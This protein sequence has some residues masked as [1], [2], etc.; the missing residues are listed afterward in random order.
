[1]RTTF[2]L[3]LAC[4]SVFASLGQ[5]LHHTFDTPE[6]KRSDTLNVVHYDVALD[7]TDSVNKEIVGLAKVTVLSK[8]QGLKAIKLD[9]LELTVDSVWI[10]G[11][12]TT[13]WTYNDTFL[14]IST[15]PKNKGDTT[16]VKV[17]YHGVPF[18]ERWGGW[19]N[20]AN[21]IFNLGVG[22]ESIPHNLGKV[23]HPCLDNFINRATYTVTLK[24]YGSWVGVGSGVLTQVDT[25]Q[26]NP[27]IIERTWNL[28][29]AIPTYLY[30][31]ASGR[32]VLL[33]DTLSGPFTTVTSDFYV[34]PNQITSIQSKTQRLEDCFSLFEQ[35]YGKYR[36]DRVGY[37]TTSQG[38]MEHATNIAIPLSAPETTI[39]HE[40]AHSW[41]GNLITCAS[42]RDMWINEGMAVFSE[43]LFAEDAY[44]EETAR[45]NMQSDL[46]TVL[47]SAHKQEDG[48]QPISGV[49]RV[50]TY[51]THTYRKGALVGHNLRVKLGDQKAFSGFKAFL[52]S[53]AFS[54]V[55]SYQLKSGLENATGEDL[56]GFFNNWVFGPGMPCYVIDSFKVTPSAGL[57]QVKLTV[58]Q[59]KANSEEFYSTMPLDVLFM[60]AQFNRFEKT[61][62]VAGP[63]TTVQFQLPIDASYATLNP[64]HELNYAMTST[65]QTVTSNDR[66]SSERLNVGVS[67]S[68]VSSDSAFVRAQTYWT[69]PHISLRNSV[70]LGVRVN[71][72]RYWR[73]AG[74]GSAQFT[75]SGAYNAKKNES[76]YGLV[77]A[78]EDSIVLLYRP[79]PDQPW[80]IQKDASINSGLS[81]DSLGGFR[82]EGASFGE[83]VLAEYDSSF[84]ESIFNNLT[85]QE[86]D[87]ERQLN[88]F[89]VPASNYINIEVK[90]TAAAEIVILNIKGE[91]VMALE[92][93]NDQ[94][95][96]DVSSWKPGVYFVLL[97]TKKGAEIIDYKRFIKE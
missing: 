31:I 92:K 74:V 29:Q 59:L 12:K 95:T 70:D 48:Y 52:D 78:N 53:N 38:A 69:G 58:R 5:H 73:I 80:T 10:N 7:L 25:V 85:L 11:S 9:L 91:E 19:Y 63:L 75:L 32:Y 72:N 54:S 42:D 6:S 66:I 79:Q 35:R 62:E 14:I 67:L 82:I 55:N 86:A 76:D 40:L 49:P 4:V 16:K 36:W 34:L 57:Y 17:A 88:L 27:R 33:K 2:L 26:T 97:Y 71:I 45:N 68:S 23:W 84:N 1:M 28:Q 30:G 21:Y 83:Y 87:T 43:Y 60:D 93:T 65:S 8:I 56:T 51:G 37:S 94:L 96:L 50:H 46:Y 3:L 39:M 18:G 77:A 41:W 20:N 47:N 90:H 89:P 24:T 64:N 81:T 15:A 22:F 13:N 44:G 61:I